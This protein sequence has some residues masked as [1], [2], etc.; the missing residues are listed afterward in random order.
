MSNSSRTLVVCLVV[1]LALGGGAALY[2]NWG[3]SKPDDKDSSNKGLSAKNIPPSKTPEVSPDRP[4][5]VPFI[6]WGGDVA[7]FVA[8]GG[9][10]TKA[11][12]LFARHK[13]NVNLSPGDD[14]KEQVK[15]YL[16]GKSPFLRGT[17]SMLGQV[18]DQLTSRPELT[19]VVFLQLTWSAGDHL[20][21]RE[22]FA[23]LND[24]RGKKIALQSGGPHV[25]MLNDILNTAQLSWKDIT[26]VWTDDVSGDKG[27][28]ALFRKDRSIDACFV[29]TPERDE[30]CGGL[31]SK[32]TGEGQSVKGSHVVVSTAHMSRSIADVYACRKDFFEKHRDWVESFTAGYLK[33]TEDLVATRKKA[34]V[35]WKNAPEGEAYR[36]MIKLAQSIW[37]QDKAFKDQVAKEED[38]DG[39]IAD[40]S[41]VGLPGNE[42][43]FKQKGNLSGFRNKM[44]MALVLPD[45]PAAQ[46][47]RTNPREFEAANL[48]YDALRGKGS[49]TGKPLKNARITG[50][51]KIEPEKII[52]SF[53]IFF[54]PDKSDFPEAR[55]G[56][57]YQRA[58]EMASLFGNSAVGI[59]G[60]ADPRLFVERFAMAAKKDGLI[61]SGNFPGPFTLRDGSELKLTEI[62]RILKLI[63]ENNLAVTESGSTLPM[64]A[65]VERLDELSEK[66][67]QEVRQ[68]LMGYARRHDLVIEDSQIRREG[69]GVKEPRYAVP[70]NNEQTAANRRVEFTIV[71]VP[72]EQVEADQFGF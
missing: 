12:S 27:P 1:L 22:S 40:A 55:Y 30:L 48:D 5:K 10:E 9:L 34:G 56:G 60:H 69:V 31:D 23:T 51:V 16:E 36:G 39:L 70:S 26:V 53:N 43:F 62:P 19:P 57:D 72:A 3:E 35:N 61:K 21:G 66:R 46:P 49:L 44:R 67:S 20:V 33:A 2:K 8:N 11:D 24:L 71:K 52:Y 17:L 59:R 29:I 63:A 7:T 42:A 37:S 15:D 4:V 6:F 32:G 68:S 65:A 25:G 13:L 54:E 14:F 64:R 18:S 28:A 47:L 58:L 50:E 38:V 45:D 41:F